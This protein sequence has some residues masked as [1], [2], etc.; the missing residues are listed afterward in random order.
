MADL[1]PMEELR[2]IAKKNDSEVTLAHNEIQAEY[3]KAKQELH[4]NADFQS[5]TTQIVERSAKA[6][7][8][9]EML[10]IL[11]HEQKN[12]LSAYLLECE[13][14]KL[15]YRKNKEKKVIQEEIKA[16][17]AN[18]KI[19]AL[20]KRYGYLYKKDENGEPIGFIANKMVNKYKEFCNWWEGTSDGFKRIVKGT[21][22]IVFWAGLAI[23]ICV[24][25]YRAVKWIA[26]NTQ[27]L[28]NIQ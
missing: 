7:L 15:D 28:P 24:L 23:I 2:E 16:E 27:N 8:T 9:E 1:I 25:G 12:E 6:E 17:V 14:K 3:E 13:K 22:K 26:D 21:L 20:K 4:N 11:T 19:E 10:K 5:L 18:K